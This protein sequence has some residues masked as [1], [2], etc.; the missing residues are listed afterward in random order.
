MHK[1]SKWEINVICYIKVVTAI[2][3]KIKKKSN[4]PAGITG[5]DNDW[6]VSDRENEI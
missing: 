4:S 1:I 5:S 3:N 6:P 2:K